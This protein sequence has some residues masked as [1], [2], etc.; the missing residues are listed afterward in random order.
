MANI[1]EIPEFNNNDNLINNLEYPDEIPMNDINNPMN[2]PMNN[3]CPPGNF[4]YFNMIDN[5]N[6]NAFPQLNH[7]VAKICKIQNQF[8]EFLNINF[9]NDL[10]INNETDMKNIIDNIDTG[11]QHID[12]LLSLF[13]EQQRKVIQIE[14]DMDKS[15]SSIQNDSNKLNEFSEFTQKINSKYKD[16]NNEKLNNCI[17]E[18]CESIKEKSENLELKDTYQK[19]L[20]I[21]KYLFHNFLKKINQGNIGSTCSLCLQKQ[22]DTFLEPCGHTGCSECIKKY[23]DMSEN[24]KCFIC[25]KSIFKQHKLYFI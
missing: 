1:N 22:V 23:I 6:N 8:N 18:I 25:R 17:L 20:Y 10:D 9:T 19:E 4:F 12:K 14:K 2:N 3:Y 16:I 11:I 21:L 5:L 24:P 13:D 7:P 15:I